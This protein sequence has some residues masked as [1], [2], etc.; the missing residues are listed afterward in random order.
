MQDGNLY[1]FFMHS[2]FKVQ[3]KNTFQILWYIWYKCIGCYCSSILLTC[4]SVAWVLNLFYSYTWC[5][6]PRTRLMFVFNISHS[7]F[8]KLYMSIFC[9][10]CFRL[11]IFPVL[12]NVSWTVNYQ[13]LL[14]CLFSSAN[15]YTCTKKTWTRDEAII[16]VKLR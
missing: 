11:L 5:K 9:H 10:F 15:F 14:H 12:L 4:S 16:Q 2:F 13:L 6:C 3:L 1:T 7:A 8:A